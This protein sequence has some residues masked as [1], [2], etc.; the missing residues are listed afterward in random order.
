MLYLKYSG[1]TLVTRFVNSR[2]STTSTVFE[3]TSVNDTSNWVLGI[4]NE[5]ISK[6]TQIEISEYLT[7]FS[8]Q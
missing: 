2:K 8:I 3:L 6:F 5:E 4:Q 1:K 7:C